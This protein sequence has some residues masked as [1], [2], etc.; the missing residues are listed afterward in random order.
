MNKRTYAP[1]SEL[2]AHIAA[3]SGAF[4]VPIKYEMPPPEASPGGITE[5]A[6]MYR[7]IYKR[8]GARLAVPHSRT[9]V[10][11]CLPI[12]DDVTYLRALHEFGHIIHPGG[13]L[14]G[15]YRSAQ[16]LNEANFGLVLMEEENA[17]SWAMQHSI[18]W[19]PAMQD[20]LDRTFLS[21]YNHPWNPRRKK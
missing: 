13:F 12:T 5:A 7:T 4:N 1:L 10:L 3:L 11:Y 15:D 6:V 20:E 2:Q 14:R 21:Y 8:V 9:L 16:T 18:I 17:W 19:T